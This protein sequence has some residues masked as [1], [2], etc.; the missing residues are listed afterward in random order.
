MFLL[1]DPT[2]TNGALNE[3]MEEE[4]LSMSTQI[5]TQGAIKAGWL[6]KRG[7]RWKSWHKRWCVLASRGLFYFKTQ[8]DSK[9]AGVVV[10]RGC[11]VEDAALHEDISQDNCFCVRTPMRNYYFSAENEMEKM[12]WIDTLS[13]AVA[14]R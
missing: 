9:A 14:N 5:C 1:T 2:F 10:M 8:S 11:S 6:T 13:A 4:M 3:R 7:G 12:D